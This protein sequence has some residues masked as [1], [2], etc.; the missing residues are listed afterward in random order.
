MWKWI[1]F[2]HVEDLF[3]THETIIRI[4]FVHHNF[5]IVTHGEKM[6]K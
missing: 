3:L 1:G 6:H 4:K 5:A 2:A